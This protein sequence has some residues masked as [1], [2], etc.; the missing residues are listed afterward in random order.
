MT[1]QDGPAKPL[2]DEDAITDIYD[3]RTYDDAEEVKW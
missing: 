2:M 1:E 3:D